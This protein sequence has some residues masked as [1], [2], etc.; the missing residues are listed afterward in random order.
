MRVRR[1]WDIR[2]ELEDEHLL[3]GLGLSGHIGYR[4]KKDVWEVLFPLHH[5]NL[6]RKKN[7]TENWEMFNHN[8]GDK[9]QLTILPKMSH[10]SELMA[11]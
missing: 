5:Y 2:K 10:S 6:G 1:G 7:K 3:N 9:Y 11:K 8:A 4:K